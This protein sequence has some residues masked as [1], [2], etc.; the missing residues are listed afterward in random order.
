MSLEVLHLT[1]MLLGGGACLERPQISSSLGLRV[2]FPRIQP[3][4]ARAEFSYHMIV[5]SAS[6]GKSCIR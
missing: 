3:I 6:F 4:F 1:L 2:D 5:E